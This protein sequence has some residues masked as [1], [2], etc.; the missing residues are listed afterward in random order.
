MLGFRI[1]DKP[2]TLEIILKPPY[3]DHI[4]LSRRGYLVVTGHHVATI[5][6]YFKMS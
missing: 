1:G 6:E 4:D 3:N 5:R 2:R